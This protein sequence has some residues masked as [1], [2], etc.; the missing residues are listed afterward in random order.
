[1]NRW[2]CPLREGAL[3]ARGIP[4]QRASLPLSGLFGEADYA[5]APARLPERA[6]GVARL[7]AL[8][9]LR[10]PPLPDW[11]PSEVFEHPLKVQESLFWS[12]ANRRRTIREPLL[13]SLRTHRE[14]VPPSGPGTEETTPFSTGVPGPDV[15]TERLSILGDR[16]ISL[17]CA[18]CDG[19]CA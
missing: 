10:R 4:A 6:K 15:R 14:F 2:N 11:R 7:Q 12:P 8:F 17:Q 19:A 1:M 9:E 3:A 16:R 13:C 18:T 5:E